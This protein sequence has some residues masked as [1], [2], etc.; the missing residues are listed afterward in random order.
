MSERACAI[1]VK[2]DSILLIYRK[3]QGREYYVI[4]GGSVESGETPEDACIRETREETGLD[5]EIE[6]MLGS[7]ENE[8]RTDHYFIVKNFTGELV[9][10]GPELQRLVPDN[11][12][13]LEWTLLNQ[14]NIINLKPSW[15]KQILMNF[16]SSNFFSS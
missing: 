13:R 1:L 10:G 7:F 16:F 3:K 14:L 2:E 11:F 15:L 8:G 9:L 6:G 5:I 12:Y 4:P